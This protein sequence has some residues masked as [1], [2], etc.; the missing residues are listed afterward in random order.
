MSET[1]KLYPLEFLV[2]GTPRTQQTKSSKSREDWKRR[3]AEAADK[4]ISAINGATTPDGRPISA[5][6]YYCPTDQMAGDIDNIVKP[7]LDALI[8][9]AYLDDG[10]IERVTVQKFEPG[11]GWTFA[12]QTTELSKAIEE[13]QPVVYIRLED[14]LSWRQV[15]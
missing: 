2:I 8:G 12:N 13:D 3:V 4:Q 14:D 7:I 15:G 1:P 11:G 10:A 6:I 5:M 9:I